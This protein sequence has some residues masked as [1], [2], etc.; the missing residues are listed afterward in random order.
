MWIIVK[1]WLEHPPQ[2]ITQQR[3]HKHV[4]FDYIVFELVQYLLPRIM[5][6]FWLPI[7]KTNPNITNR[8]MPKEKKY[9]HIKILIKENRKKTFGVLP[10]TFNL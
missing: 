5:S 2:N 10:S 1:K 8:K 3:K 6:W 9:I 7:N 4:I